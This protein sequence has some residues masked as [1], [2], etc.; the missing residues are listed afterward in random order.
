M[1]EEDDQ[2][3]SFIENDIDFSS[4]VMEF[5]TGDFKSRDRTSLHS[6]RGSLS[7]SIDNKRLDEINRT[8]N[9][10]SVTE[11]ESFTKKLEI[12]SKSSGIPLNPDLLSLLPKITR[13]RY[14]SALGVL[15]GWA[16]LKNYQ[17]D[18]EQIKDLSKKNNIFMI[19]RYATFLKNL[20]K[21]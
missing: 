19:I 12:V 14:R 7:T 21:K 1:E 15:L 6:E 16:S 20:I 17:L 5:D 18:E 9:K 3:S 4:P 2:Y 11:I 10:L 13:L 8:M